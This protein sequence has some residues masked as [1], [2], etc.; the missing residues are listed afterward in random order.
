MA[1]FT[2]FR[3]YLGDIKIGKKTLVVLMTPENARI[4]NFVFSLLPFLALFFI[5][6][7]K[8]WAITPNLI[9]SVLIFISF[10]ICQYTAFLYFKNFKGEKTY[11]LLKCNFQGAVIFQISFMALIK[12][13]LS[14][15][16]FVIVFILINNL[17]NYYRDPLG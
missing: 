2:Y 9:F 11:Y 14:V 10:I 13:L 8:F 4:L 1:F 6:Y 12:P 3:D 16:V 15:I 5:V 17:F 7:F